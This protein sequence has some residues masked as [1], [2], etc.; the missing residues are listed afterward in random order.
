MTKQQLVFIIEKHKQISRKMKEIA[1]HQAAISTSIAEICDI[2]H[3]V[4]N[5]VH[6]CGDELFAKAEIE[7]RA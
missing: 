2:E 6:K 1:E 4:L 7:T 3:E 5:F